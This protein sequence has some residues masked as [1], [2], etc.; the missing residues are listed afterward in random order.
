MDFDWQGL[1]DVLRFFFSTPFLKKGVRLAGIDIRCLR[2]RW[3]RDSGTISWNTSALPNPG[4]HTIIATAQ[5]HNSAGETATFDSTL[6]SGNGRAADDVVADIRLKSLTFNNSI[7]L[8]YSASA[9]PAPTPDPALVP[10]PKLVLDQNGNITAPL[11]SMAYTKG[12]TIPF[13]IKLYPLTG[14]ATVG[15]TLNLTAKPIGT[16]EAGL[17][18]YQTGTVPK[19]LT[20]PFSLNAQVALY[21]EVDKQ[22]L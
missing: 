12:A 3:D 11:T 1:T 13:A 20:N 14:T 7:P 18:L 10:M 17:I 2:R 4:E 16:N 15:Y 19:V 22:Y 5:V 6:V 21:N 9:N 8:R